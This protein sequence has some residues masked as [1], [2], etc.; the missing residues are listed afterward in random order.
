MRKSVIRDD[1][2]SYFWSRAYCYS[3]ITNYLRRKIMKEFEVIEINASTPFERGVQYGKAAADK[4]IAGVNNYRAYFESKGRTWEKTKELA[5]AFVPDIEEAMP[6][7][8][9]EAKG[10]AE[11]AGVEFEGLMVLNTRYELTNYPIEAVPE[12]TTGAILPEATKDHVT[13]MVKNWDY[14]PGVLDKIVLLHITQEDGTRIFGLTEAGQLLRE[15]YNN[16]GVGLC[17]NYIG[18]VYDGPGGGIPVCFLRRKVLGC[19]TFEEA[20]KWVTGIKRSVSNNSLLVGGEGKAIDIEASPVGC[21]LIHPVGGIVTH[22][23]HFSVDP[24]KDVRDGVSME[25]NRMVRLAG[26]LYHNYGEITPESLMEIMKDHEF[27]PDSICN[28]HNSGDMTDM[29]GLMTVASI[30]V[31]FANQCSY[32]CKGNPCEGEYKKYLI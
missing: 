16:R 5:M 14:K 9:E 24:S 29:S 15:G 22:A 8:L 25:K 1:L 23:N 20:Y 11:G 2:F 7:V 12:C 31:D 26:L 32:V 28:H 10:V 19:Q 21:D 30:I 18:S 6:E 17:N 3:E 27:Y 13:Y 4:I